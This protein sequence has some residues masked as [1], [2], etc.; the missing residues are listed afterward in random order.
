MTV[1]VQFLWVLVMKGDE[2]F[3]AST[4]FLVSISPASLSWFMNLSFLK[5]LIM[6]TV[7]FQHS[8][9]AEEKFLVIS[10]KISHKISLTVL[11]PGVL[12]HHLVIEAVVHFCPQL[13]SLVQAVV[14]S[15][16]IVP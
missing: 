2:N 5:R 1:S 14:E 6:L 11:C 3:V 7:P 9:L 4:Q 12:P 15:R 10:H 8:H 16:L 13:L